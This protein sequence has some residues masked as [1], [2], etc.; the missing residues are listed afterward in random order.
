M[1]DNKPF[2]T[3]RICKSC[4]EEKIKEE[5]FY[6]NSNTGYYNNHCKVCINQRK[7]KNKSTMYVSKAQVKSK[8]CIHCEKEKELNKENFTVRNNKFS[9]SCK[10]CYD[11]FLL[12]NREDKDNY[13]KET[14]VNNN[15]KYTVSRKYTVYR[16][17]DFN[18]GRELGLTKEFLEECLLS[19]CVYCSYPAT[20][21]DRLDNL[22]GHT[23]ANCVPCCTQCNVAK[24]N[25]FTYEDMLK[26]GKAIKEV[27][28]SR[29]L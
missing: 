7:T 22:I 27:K 3:K 15:L 26:I 6:Y 16:I 17:E 29:N 1:E 10:E 21:L 5:D 2:M 8:V 23:D 20:G 25:Y 14:E 18:K 12:K 24:S 11:K 4:K 19:K 9:N 28:I 13:L